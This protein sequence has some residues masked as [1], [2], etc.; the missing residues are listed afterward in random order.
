MISKGLFEMAMAIRYGENY[1]LNTIRDAVILGL[2]YVTG[3]RPV[4]LAKLAVKDLRIDTRNSETGL[5]RYSLLL[6]YAKQRHVTTERLFLAIPAEIGALIRHY[7]E[8][9]QLKPDGKLFEFSHSAPFNVSRRLTR[10]SS[11]SVRQIIRLP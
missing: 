4:Q 1:S 11:V 5:I 6:P 8:R 10:P 3:A 9:A 7:I 2:T